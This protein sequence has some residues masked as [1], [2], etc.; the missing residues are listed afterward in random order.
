MQ[1]ESLSPLH[2]LV[3]QQPLTFL[4]FAKKRGPLADRVRLLR[5]ARDFDSLESDLNGRKKLTEVRR[6]SLQDQR[7]QIVLLLLGVLTSSHEGQQAFL[8]AAALLR[9]AAGRAERAER[10]LKELSQRF[11][12]SINDLNV[13]FKSS[14]DVP[15]ARRRLSRRLNLTLEQ[16]DVVENELRRHFRTLREA[17]RVLGSDREK[18][19]NLLKELSNSR[20]S[21]RRRGRSARTVRGNP[22]PVQTLVVES[23]PA[24]MRGTAVVARAK[25]RPR[26]TIG[27]KVPVLG[28]SVEVDA[29]TV[30]VGAH[31]EALCFRNVVWPAWDRL[32]NS[33]KHA[34]LELISRIAAEYWTVTPEVDG[35]LERVRRTAVTDGIGDD[36]YQLIKA[37][38]WPASTTYGDAVGFDMVQPSADGRDWICVEVKSTAGPADSPFLM[39]RNEWAVAEREADRYA[40]YRVSWVLAPDPVVNIMPGLAS[41]VASGALSLAPSQYVLHVRSLGSR[42]P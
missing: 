32:I 4:E 28:V 1:S 34:A 30:E 21:E 36:G 2:A 12:E 41:L 35:L 39:S 27:R 18:I 11:G 25:V 40:I 42:L 9:Q 5:A 19:S 22:S 33:N 31:G 20:R 13:M 16:L 23:N 10:S 24:P 38:V 17:E 26:L 7:H 3:E 37:L 29:G 8:A 6:K 14:T 15:P